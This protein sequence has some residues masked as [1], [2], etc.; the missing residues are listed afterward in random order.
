M[1][2]CPELLIET[3]ARAVEGAGAGA[4][5]ME[6]QMGQSRPFDVQLDDITSLAKANRFPDNSSVCVRERESES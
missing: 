3:L 6:L 1:G 5:E 4:E 2:C